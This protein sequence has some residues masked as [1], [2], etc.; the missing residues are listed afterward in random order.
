[1]HISCCPDNFHDIF[2]HKE[3]STRQV[4]T[5]YTHLAVLLEN[6][7]NFIETYPMAVVFRQITVNATKIALI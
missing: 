1:M 7:N 6:V 5:Q 3:L 4:D 2:S